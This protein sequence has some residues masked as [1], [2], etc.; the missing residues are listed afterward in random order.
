MPR[1]YAEDEPELEEGLEEDF[2][3]ETDEAFEEDVEELVDDESYVEDE[4]DDGGEY[5]DDENGYSEEDY[6]DV[7]SVF[8]GGT[9]NDSTWRE[10]LIPMLEIGYFNPV[11]EEWDENA[12]ENER[13]W[14]DHCDYVLYCVTEEIAGVYSIAEIVD[15]SNKR[16]EK[17][18]FAYIGDFEEKMLHSLEAVAELIKMNG[19][20]SFTSLKAVAD[21]VNA[22]VVDEE[23]EV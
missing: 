17:A 10:E 18:I 8:L 21:Y 12:Q 5:F 15:D 23:E 6:S 11:V 1:Y 7:P 9:T 2:E 3:E 14:R 13:Y 16:P 4:G 19:G 22:G 20:Q